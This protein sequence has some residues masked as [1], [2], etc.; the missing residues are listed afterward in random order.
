MS[1]KK[2]KHLFTILLLIGLMIPAVAAAQSTSPNYQ[3]EE[4]TFGTGGGVDLNSTNYQAQGSAGSLGV[5][6]GSSTNYD[7]ESGFLTANEPFLE[8]I[9]NNTNLDL[10]TLSQS[11]VSYGSVTFSVRSYLS[12]TYSVKT[13]S[14][15]PTSEGGAQLAAMNT[16]AGSSPGTEQFGINL[17]DNATP[18]VGAYPSNIPDN[19]FADGQAASGYDTPD[20]FKY[21]VGDTIARSAATAGNQAV[22][23][24]NYTISYIANISSIT[25]AGVY[26]MNHDLMAVAT[27]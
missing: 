8:M 14:Q 5:G 19:T 10:G 9:I 21:V 23:Q 22:G 3:V 16:A 13:L 18:N 12:S 1:W 15:P 4:M 7:A 26:T 6:S 11:S 25:P 17:V 20:Q 2:Q 27:Y 24:T